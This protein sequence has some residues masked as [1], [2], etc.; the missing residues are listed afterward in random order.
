MEGHDDHG[1]VTAEP[2]LFAGVI[3]VNAT[4]NLLHVAFGVLGVRASQDVGWSRRYVGLGAAFFGALAGLD[5]ALFGFDRGLHT[6]EGVALNGWAS[7]GHALLAA[8]GAYAAIRSG[9]R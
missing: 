5:W 3:A 8:A 6:L 1:L 2:G 4:H 9:S 7:L